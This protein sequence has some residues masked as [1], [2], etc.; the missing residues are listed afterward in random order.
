MRELLSSYEN[1]YGTFWLIMQV[2]RIRKLGRKLLASRVELVA[3]CFRWRG[4]RI[5]RNVTNLF[6]LTTARLGRCMPMSVTWVCSHFCTVSRVRA[7]SDYQ[8]SGCLGRVDNLFG[9]RTNRTRLTLMA[10]ALLASHL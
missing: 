7:G 4:R 10:L 5:Q 8:L 3:E 9:C 6:R 1:H 2:W